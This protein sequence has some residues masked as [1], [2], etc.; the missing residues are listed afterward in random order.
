M[1]VTDFDGKNVYIVGGSSGMGLATGKELSSLGSNVIIFARGKE[2]LEQAVEAISA[3][4]KSGAQRFAFKQMDVSVH[5]EVNKVMEEAVKEFGPPDIL[6]NVAGRAYPN[7]FE[8]ISY[9]QFDE[10]MKV[11]IYG[12]WNTISALFPHMKERGG[13]I[14]NFS[15]ALGFMGMFGYSDYCPSKYAILGLSEVLKSEFK[16]YNIGI[17]VVCPADVDTPGFEVENRTKPPETVAASEAGGVLQPAEVARDVIKGLRKGR[18]FISPGSVAMIY[19]VK[20]FFP[21]FVE[22]SVERSIRKAVP[23]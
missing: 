16:R 19:R 6:M 4:R 11:H 10:T 20:R 21:W 5:D 14:V 1:K 15:S 2:R 9:E 8:N 3:G 7:Y 12:Q 22:M 17:S 18:Y 13:Y 23:R